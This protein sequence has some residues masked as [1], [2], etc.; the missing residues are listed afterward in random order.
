MQFPNVLI[1]IRSKYSNNVPHLA[2]VGRFLNAS[3]EPELPKDFRWIFPLPSGKG[4]IHCFSGYFTWAS[5]IF[6][7]RIASKPDVPSSEYRGTK[8][9]PIFHQ[10]V[11]N[12]HTASLA[13]ITSRLSPLLNLSG[14]IK[15]PRL[16]VMWRR[17]G[18]LIQM[19]TI[20]ATW[21]LSGQLTMF[22]WGVELRP[23]CVL[24]LKPRPI[25]LSHSAPTINCF[26]C[27]QY[28]EMLHLYL[29]TVWQL[30]PRNLRLT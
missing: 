2:S 1:E 5:W 16:S 6:P 9:K 18:S 20:R 23:R 12:Q 10:I 29:L 27:R 13:V 8:H 3:G 21:W 7:C 26:I 17:F 22:P 15:P 4:I 24:I 30:F 11:P 28:F 14:I 19:W 25:Q